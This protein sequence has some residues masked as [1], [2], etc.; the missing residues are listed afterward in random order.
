MPAAR[1]NAYTDVAI[2]QRGPYTQEITNPLPRV[3]NDQAQTD[4][5]DVA[6][7]DVGHEN[8][9][10]QPPNSPVAWKPGRDLYANG[11]GVGQDFLANQG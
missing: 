7:T 4:V 5:Y 3:G 11:G 10:E 8:D 6:G 1:P 9:V 2:T